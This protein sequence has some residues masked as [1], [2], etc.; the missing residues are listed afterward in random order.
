VVAQ[1]IMRVKFEKGYVNP[2]FALW[3]RMATDAGIPENRSVQ[4]WVQAKLP[5]QY[6]HHIIVTPMTPVNFEKGKK[7]DY[8]KCQNLEET[9]EY[10]QKDTTLPNGL[11]ELLNDDDIWALYKPTG[12][13]INLLRDNFASLGKGDKSAY[14]DALQSIRHFLRSN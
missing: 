5:S 12:Q 3:L 4:L 9:R 1:L 2:S 10:V 6:Q 11:K 7:L 13:E 14:R 8:K